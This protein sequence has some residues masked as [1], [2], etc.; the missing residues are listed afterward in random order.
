M[1][2]IAGLAAINMGFIA[3]MALLA[4]AFVSGTN[5]GSMFSNMALE[6]IAMAGL[7]LLLV[8]RLFDLSVDG[9]V[10]VAGVVCGKMIVAGVAWPLAV[11]TAMAVGALVG[12]INGL[13][14][15]R[16]RINPLIATIGTWWMSIGVAYGLTRAISPYGFP[17]AFQLVGQAKL[18]DIRI[19]VWYAVAIVGVLAVVLSFTRFGRHIH[20]MGGNPEAGRLFGV[21]VERIGIQLYVM[22]GLLSAFIGVVLASRLNS[23]SPNA[24]DGMTMRAIAA[25][26]IG[27]CALSGGKGN[28]LS[29][30]LGLLLMNML[31]NAATILGVS[32]YWQKLL[33]GGV[34]L[35]ALILDATSNKIH[36]PH[37]A[38]NSGEKK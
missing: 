30:L 9:V 12:V 24:V 25:A 14:I 22:M 23:G 36:A 10:A 18:L 28:V 37:V 3:I 2:R 38:H 4:P 15:M 7:T 33:I 16:L 1:R 31:T 20:I 19:Y 11:A 6:S 26:V 34:L 35:L 13:L 32:P 5:L 27:G 17:E 29:G 8:G 21:R